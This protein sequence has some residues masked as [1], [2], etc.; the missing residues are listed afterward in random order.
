MR[1]LLRRYPFFYSKVRR[2]GLPSRT[3]ANSCGPRGISGYPGQK[4]SSAQRSL[5]DDVVAI[6]ADYLEAC[7][8]RSSS[9]G[10]LV[11]TGGRRRHRLAEA[12]QNRI[13]LLHGN[14]R[15]LRIGEL[16]LQVARGTFAVHRHLQ[17]Q[18]F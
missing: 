15:R 18:A 17:A 10:I 12:A 6:G 7:Q 16:Q 4:I 2:V 11:L 14:A 9:V 5:D 8:N 1:E 13:Q 3:S